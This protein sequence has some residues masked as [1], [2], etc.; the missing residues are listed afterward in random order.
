MTSQKA[1]LF[2]AILVG[3]VVAA[4][5]FSRF[6]PAEETV[7][8][9]Q[10]PTNISVAVKPPEVKCAAA[11]AVELSPEQVVL[12]SFETSWV[13]SG[14]MASPYSA[15]GGPLLR[16]PYAEC[17]SRTPEGA[18]YAA[19]NF[20]T[21]G[22]VAQADGV[23]R[24]FL[25]A[26]ASH[27]GNFNYLIADLANAIPVAN[28]PTIAITGYQWNSYSPDTASVQI[29]YS[30]ATGSRAGQDVSTVYNLTWEN[31]DWLLIVP[32][33]NDNVSTDPTNKTYTPWG[34]S[35]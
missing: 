14:D 5:A 15:A 32:G 19:A 20:A 13:R 31:N 29:K 1:W 8:V 22:I 17:F 11:P 2:S 6:L 18:L 26:R 23:F 7:A 28:R 16:Q 27:S 25:M 12:T 3:I 4:F 24:E 9:Q 33:R 21:E 35:S 10:D 34:G 30:L